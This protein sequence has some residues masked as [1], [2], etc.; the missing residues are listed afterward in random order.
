ME[1][2]AFIIKIKGWLKTLF[3]YGLI[4]LFASNVISYI[5]AP[6][7][8][9]ERFDMM[10]QTLKGERV[11]WSEYRGKPLVIYVWATWCPT[12]RF[13][14]PTIQSLSKEYKVVSIAVNSGSDESVERY[15]EENGYTFPVINDPHG[16]WQ[17]HL[18][19]KAFPTTFILDAEGK[20][21]LAEVGYTSGIGLRLRLAL[22]ED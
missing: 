2:N 4:F 7:P 11:E 10:A 22:G 9:A 14:S 17:R 1:T 19:V 6:K 16:V 5:R 15:L 18:E 21:L 3:V 8:S 20:Q 13:Q 12:C